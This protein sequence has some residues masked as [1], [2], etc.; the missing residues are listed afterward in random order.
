MAH[1]YCAPSRPF[2]LSH[3]FSFSNSTTNIISLCILLSKTK[4][5]SMFCRSRHDVSPIKSLKCPDEVFRSHEVFRT[6]HEMPDLIRIRI[7]SEGM[8]NSSHECWQSEANVNFTLKTCEKTWPLTEAQPNLNY[9][10]RQTCNYSVT[11]RNNIGLKC[12]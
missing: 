1:V 9:G 10:R 8:N 7:G 3:N 5:P 4:I 6:T 12:V 2:Y 11:S